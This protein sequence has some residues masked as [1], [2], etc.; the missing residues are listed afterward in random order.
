MMNL[1]SKLHLAIRPTRKS[2]SSGKWDQSGSESSGAAGAGAGTG[3]GGRAAPPPRMMSLASLPA[4]LLRKIAACCDLL[5]ILAL[6]GTCRAIRGGVDDASVYMESLRM[7]IPPFTSLCVIGR[8]AL[9][10]ALKAQLAGHEPAMRVWAAMAVAVERRASLR[11]KVRA[12]LVPLL[13]VCRTRADDGSPPVGPNTVEELESKIAVMSTLLVL[14]YS[15]ICDLETSNYLMSL[16]SWRTKQR[17]W[18]ESK[19]LE[20]RQLN[21]QI[22]FSMVMGAIQPPPWTLGGDEHDRRMK[23]LAYR[24]KAEYH[25]HNLSHV[26][27]AFSTTWE[28]L[29]TR[30]LQ[31]AGVMAYLLRAKGQED[32]PRADRIPYLDPSVCDDDSRNDDADTAQP[33]PKL[34]LLDRTDGTTSS[35]LTTSGRS[36]QEWYSSRAQ[37]V[38]SAID[39]EDWYGYY[40]YSLEMGTSSDPAMEDIRFSVAPADNGNSSSRKKSTVSAS[41]SS[42]GRGALQVEARGCKDGITR[43]FN[44]VGSVA[45]ATGM[46]SLE[47]QYVG[48]HS[49][50]YEGVVTPLGIL[51]EWGRQGATGMM[52]YFWLWKRSWMDRDV[53]V[54]S[55]PYY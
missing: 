29:Q 5:D 52:G 48:A 22:A 14:G 40:I 34:P 9:L 10:D 38:V 41:S 35:Y 18:R 49:W 53:K 25:S 21:L 31:L 7:H 24:V 30:S 19:L 1:R 17:L 37:E 33:A 4:E 28:G 3:A 55:L 32:L 50:A 46:V 44:F 12:F 8:D 45:A 43:A 47:K 27:D 13:E 42:S 11:N 54:D 16:N 39:E 6:R 36:W 15:N 20:N 26:N 51:G 2:S 23:E